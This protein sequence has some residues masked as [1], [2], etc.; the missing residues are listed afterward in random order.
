[1]ADSE[2]KVTIHNLDLQF[3]VHGDDKQVFANLFDARFEA[4]I[5]HWWRNEKDRVARERLS[6]VERSLGDRSNLPGVS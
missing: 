1:M 2:P 6:N 3:D 5:R 4:C